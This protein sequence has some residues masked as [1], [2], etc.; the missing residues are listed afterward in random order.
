MK[1]NIKRIIFAGSMTL[2]VIIACEKKLNV[3]DTN[4]PTQESYFKTAVELEKGVN[5][6]YSIIRSTPL[7]GR[8]WHYLHSMRG[9]EVAAG[10]SQLEQPNRE[11]LDQPNPL[12]GNAAISD[13]WNATYQMI[14]RANLVLSKA[15]GVTDNVTL[16]DRV[17]GEAKFLRAWAYFELTSQFGDVPMYTEPVVSSTGF[18]GK[19]PAANIYTQIISDLTDAATKLPPSYSGS[20]LG[21]ATKGAANALLGRVNLQKGDYNAAKT[22]LLAVYNSN[23]Y[24]VNIP[25]L[26]NFDGDIKS[27]NVTP[28]EVGHEFNK[29]SVFEVAFVDKG[30][31]GFGWGG[32]NTSATSAG[33]TMRAQDWG[34]VWG[35]V[36]PSNRILDEFE[37][38]DP[39]YKWTVWEA[40]DMVRTKA[41]T[42]PGVA[43]TPAEMNVDSSIRNGVKIRRVYRKY[44]LN[45]W[46]AVSGIIPSGIN[47][48][49]IRYA[50]VLLMLAECE[51]EVGTPAQA[52]VYINKVRQRPGVNMPAVAPATKNDAIKA[53]MHER[54]VELA[55]ENIDNIDILRWKKKGYI[56]SLRPDPRPGQVEF[57]PIPTSETSSNPL[58]KN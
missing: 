42:V 2:V 28:A 16:R 40:G 4:S 23:L 18:K 52:A 24:D 37:A 9:G 48:R 53:V 20:D 7:L 31:N 21:R 27:N 11:L 34:T 1:K 12:P 5:G 30:D 15:P 6:I 46:V 26:W 55:G 19:E 58:I 35:N 47:Y 13:N 38:A 36:I 41:G 39:R 22:A 56:P 33:A 44:S 10:G 49:L 43:I 50:D 54:A 17:I 32:E 8:S 29:E 3:V 14:N 45:D 25:F 51:A 57:F